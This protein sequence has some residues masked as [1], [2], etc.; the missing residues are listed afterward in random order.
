MFRLTE[1]PSSDDDDAEVWCFYQ[2]LSAV[3]GDPGGRTRV[4]SCSTTVSVDGTMA[5]IL[6]LYP[7]TSGTNA[8]ISNVG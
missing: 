4:K 5:P 6:A 8:G 7:T 2:E 3:E 1:Q